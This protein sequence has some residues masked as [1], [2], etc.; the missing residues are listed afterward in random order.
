MTLYGMKG[1]FQTGNVRF[2]VVS[3]T[4]RTFFNDFKIIPSLC[5]LDSVYSGNDEVRI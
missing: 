1:H 4:F 5:L 3:Q 2:E